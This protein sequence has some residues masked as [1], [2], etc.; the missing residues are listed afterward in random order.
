MFKSFNYIFLGNFHENVL[1]NKFIIKESK[2]GIGASE[3]HS[4]NSIYSYYIKNCID[5]PFN[6]NNIPFTLFQFNGNSINREMLEYYSI[7]FS[8][9]FLFLNKNKNDL[10]LKKFNKSFL[11]FMEFLPKHSVLNLDYYNNIIT[12]VN[13]LNQ[14]NV[15]LNYGQI[16]S[17]IEN[18]KSEELSVLIKDCFAKLKNCEEKKI[19]DENDL[20]FFF[21]IE[22]KYKEDFYRFVD[23]FKNNMDLSEDL[24]ISNII[25]NPI[26]DPDM[27]FDLFSNEDFFVL[28]YVTLYY[29]KYYYTLCYLIFLL[30]ILNNVENYKI[31]VNNENKNFV[32]KYND[33]IYNQ[34]FNINKKFKVLMKS[35]DSFISFKAKKAI[36]SSYFYDIS[37]PFCF[38]GKKNTAAYLTYL[39]KQNNRKIL[40]EDY[41]NIKYEDYIHFFKKYIDIDINNIKSDLVIPNVLSYDEFVY[42]N[43]DLIKLKK[44]I[45]DKEIDIKQLF[46][47]YKFDE[48]DNLINFEDLEFYF[49]NLK[50]NALYGNDTF[51]FYNIRNS[52]YLD[53]I[54]PNISIDIKQKF[55][56]DYFI[57]HF[58]YI[59]KLLL[60]R[61]NNFF[62][63]NLEYVLFDESSYCFNNLDY[64]SNEKKKEFF[65]ILEKFLKGFKSIIGNKRHTYMRLIDTQRVYY[66]RFLDTLNT[67]DLELIYNLKKLKQITLKEIYTIEH[68]LYSLYTKI[69]QNVLII[70]DMRKDYVEWISLLHINKMNGFWDFPMM[71][72]SKGFLFL[73]YSYF[74]FLEELV[75]EERLLDHIYNITMNAFRIIEKHYNYIRLNVLIENGN[76]PK[77]LNLVKEDWLYI[78]E[79]LEPKD[80]LIIIKLYN[81]KANLFKSEPWSP[82]VT[83]KKILY[84]LSNCAERQYLI[85]GSQEYL[86]WNKFFK[87]YKKRKT[88]IYPLSITNIEIVYTFLDYYIN[89]TYYEDK[90]DILFNDFLISNDLIFSPLDNSYII[91]NKKDNIIKKNVEIESMDSIDINDFD[92]I[93]LI[94]NINKQLD[95]EF[96]IITEDTEYVIADD[97]SDSIYLAEIYDNL[98]ISLDTLNYY[99]KEINMISL[100]SNFKDFLLYNIK[101]LENKYLKNSNIFNLTIEFN[102]LFYLIKSYKNVIAL[103]LKGSEFEHFDTEG[104]ILEMSKL[105]NEDNTYIHY[106]KSSYDIDNKFVNLILKLDKLDKLNKDNKDNYLLNIFK[107]LALKKVCYI[108]KYNFVDKHLFDFFLNIYIKSDLNTNDFFLKLKNSIYFHNYENI[109]KFFN[110]FSF[111]FCNL[112]DGLTY[113]YNS[114]Y[115]YFYKAFFLLNLLEKFNKILNLYFS[116]FNDKNNNKFLI[117]NEL[118]EKV[119]S[120]KDHLFLINLLLN[121]KDPIY[122][123]NIL[124][125]DFNIYISNII[126]VRKVLNKVDY[127]SDKFNLYFNNF[128][129]DNSNL[130]MIGENYYF[131]NFFSN[132]NINLL[133]YHFSILDNYVYYNKGFFNFDKF[134]KDIIITNIYDYLNLNNINIFNNNIFITFNSIKNYEF[135]DIYNLDLNLINEFNDEMDYIRVL[136]KS[137]EI[138]NFTLLFKKKV[139]IKRSVSMDNLKIKYKK[140]DIKPEVVVKKSAIEEIDS[141]KTEN[142]H[143]KQDCTNKNFIDFRQW[144][145][146]LKFIGVFKYCKVLCNEML[147][148]INS[149]IW[150]DVRHIIKNKENLCIFVD[151]MKEENKRAIFEGIWFKAVRNIELKKKN[152]TDRILESELHWPVLVQNV[153]ND[154]F[155]NEFNYEAYQWRKN[156]FSDYGWLNFNHKHKSKEE[157]KAASEEAEIWWNNFVKQHKKNDSN[158]ISSTSVGREDEIYD[159]HKLQYWNSE[160]WWKKI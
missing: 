46:S 126:N 34:H 152:K 154:D 28:D 10:D 122:L 52:E 68:S 119:K 90:K 121:V 66:S 127:E 147:Y 62:N 103:D 158:A 107:T 142:R 16:F 129:N 18:L 131:N 37:E 153:L 3:I 32:T 60:N 54:N 112:K 149:V 36:I 124:Y 139:K 30:K 55:Q 67:I 15:P 75:I 98:E 5:S 64:Y 92:Y 134:N 22:D 104:I 123:Y 44:Q 145:S 9:K 80:P 132:D 2:F 155:V 140:E 151:A 94:N 120:D 12:P 128:I 71:E 99:K 73:K 109:S 23:K 133:N 84:E 138:K 70:G 74:S 96:N 130:D 148:D 47:F 102:D 144:A 101:I 115:N 49:H 65:K 21:E 4:W 50:G 43:V 125:L 33:I 51:F 8:Y 63:I 157:A 1:N 59:L 11:S 76:F 111:E 25:K 141:I 137:K 86:E 48:F 135:K 106:F 116:F 83:F 85:K 114:F 6:D 14:F 105:V 159:I 150:D 95:N 17:D 160:D 100:N 24:K 53:F 82:S 42:G 13:P 146:D 20:S 93:S 40:F 61:Q 39:Y 19:I 78:F 72:N 27:L 56:R 117:L 87:E 41:K 38:K 29:N 7:L 113:I 143:K 136:E 26:K 156:F 58:N 79:K 88:I 118:I 89:N 57:V 110:K 91:A 77:T 69:E 81:S 45:D 97:I 108:N 35:V 31:Y